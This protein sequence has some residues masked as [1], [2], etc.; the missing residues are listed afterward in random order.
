MSHF[1]K[2]INKDINIAFSKNNKMIEDSQIVQT[3]EEN[4]SSETEIE[5]KLG[6]LLIKGWTMTSDS[7]PI[8]S[9]LTFI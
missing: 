8:E 3:S 2:I 5:K 6:V 7:C 4:T 9:N 1:K